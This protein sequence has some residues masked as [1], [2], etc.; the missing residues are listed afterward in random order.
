MPSTGGDMDDG[1][2]VGGWNLP[3]PNIT[4]GGL[5]QSTSVVCWSG[6]LP[7]VKQDCSASFSKHYL[8]YLFNGFVDKLKKI[9]RD[10]FKI[11]FN[12][13][14]THPHTLVW[15]NPPKFMQ[16]LSGLDKSWA[17]NNL[18]NPLSGLKLLW[19]KKEAPAKGGEKD[20]WGGWHLGYSNAVCR[21]ELFYPKLERAR[22]AGFRPDKRIVK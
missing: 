8:Q 14:L 13:K 20:L 2:G 18:A 12:T 11:N 9:R 1:G 6:T 3:T 22:E 16:V 17:I 4:P 5:I 21:K 10:V 7:A 19:E 15:F